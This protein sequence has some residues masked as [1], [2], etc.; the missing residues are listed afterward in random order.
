MN[1]IFEHLQAPNIFESSPHNY[2]TNS[3][4]TN[5]ILQAHLDQDNP[6]GSRNN[7][8]INKSI[9][10]IKQIKPPSNVKKVADLGCGPGLYCEKLA[11]Q[12]YKVTG[13]DISE[14]SLRYAKKIAEENKLDIEYRQEDILNINSTNEYDVV[15]LI[16]Y[17]YGSMKLEERKKIL[18]K[19]YNSLKKGGVLI[20]DVSS[21]NSLQNFTEEQIWSFSK[22]NNPL[23][24]Q[25]YIAFRQALNY[26]DSVT[27]EQTTLL[28]QKNK[29]IT[30]YIWNKSFTKNNLI[31]ETND[32]G[33]KTKGVYSDVSGEVYNPNS[34]EIAI[35]LEKP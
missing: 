9:N 12:G 22:T 20:L 19:I 28:F 4:M 23:S 5:M 8:F 26:P 21:E 24:K 31:E 11:Y 30:F 15:L 7:S 10:F 17:I 25:P 34:T 18:R 32:I 14:N 6:G 1:E 3:L 13:Y 35:V 33:F 27:L 29:P 16:Y 2:W